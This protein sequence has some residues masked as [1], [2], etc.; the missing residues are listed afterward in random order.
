[1][2]AGRVIFDDHPKSL[3]H[4]RIRDIYAG[5]GGDDEVDENITSTSLPAAPP[6]DPRPGSEAFNRVS[7]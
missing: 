6:I 1:M 4:D 5:A 2:K 3:D 7:T